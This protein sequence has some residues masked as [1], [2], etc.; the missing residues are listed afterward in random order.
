MKLA[1]FAGVGVRSPI[2]CSGQRLVRPGRGV[3]RATR[4]CGE[5]RA[6]LRRGTKLAG[7][8]PGCGSVR[9]VAGL[10]SRGALQGGAACDRTDH[11]GWRI[12]L[13]LSGPFWGPLGELLGCGS[14]RGH[15]QGCRRPVRLRLRDDVC[16]FRAAVWARLLH[17]RRSRERLPRFKREKRPVFHHSTGHEVWRYVVLDARRGKGVVV[18]RC[19]T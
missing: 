17:T 16:R 3:A 9:R 15:S 10:S 19:G 7:S 6:A 5:R 11:C 8:L 14:R 2:H 18:F 13:P 12:P 1:W 4:P